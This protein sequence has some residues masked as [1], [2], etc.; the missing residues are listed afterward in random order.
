MPKKINLFQVNSDYR[1]YRKSY[2]SKIDKV[3]S[4]GKY[5]LGEN[6]YKFEETLK[7][8]TGSKYVISTSN[9]T[10]ALEVSLRSLSLASTDEVIVPSFTWV[11][12]ASSIKL[13]G[14]KPVFCDI[15]LD[16]YGLHYESLVKLV[17][18]NTKAVIIVS[19][20]GQIS[21]DIFKIRNFCKK[22]KNIF[23]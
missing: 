12:S 7:K 10:D 6:V 2:L 23:N 22:K 9:G 20:Y 18:K 8:F 1:Q 19:L 3:L 14:A 5:I 4:S 13:A 21:R 15:E 11:S 17:N 16:T